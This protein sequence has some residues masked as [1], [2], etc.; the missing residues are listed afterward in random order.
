VRTLLAGATCALA[1]LSFAPPVSA[2]T[3]DF[4]P[5]GATP[6]FECA[7]FDV[8]L[9][10]S[11]QRG[12]TLKLSARRLVETREAPQA[13]IALAGGPGQSSTRFIE[14]FAD[15]LAEGLENRQ[16]VV[17]DQRG[18]GDSGPLRCAA[19]DDAAPSTSAGDLKTAVGRC[20]QQL[21]PAR[22]YYTATEV[23]EDLEAL[24]AGL[25]V[26][27]VAIF[28]VSSGSYVAQRYA[29]RYPDH[30]D[31]L[32]L[33]SAVAQDQSGP[34]DVS[35]YR[36]V[37][38]ML[39]QLCRERACRG[40]SRDPVQDLRRLA[41]RLDSAPLRA[42]VYDRRGR[43][44]IRRLASEAELFDLLVSSDLSPALRDGLPAAIHSAATGDP[45]P[46]VRL[47]AVDDGAADP[48]E[49]DEENERAEEF[50][51][52]LFFAS[53]C[54]EKP[55]PWRSAETPIADRPAQRKAALD[56]LGR[57]AFAPF[58]RPA[59]ESTQVGTAFCERWPET[60]I[61]PVPPPGEIGA[62]ALILSGLMDVRT[63]PQEAL[64]TAALIPD[65]SLVRVPGGGHSLVSSRLGCV[66]TA[67]T[68]FFA[69][70]A[71]GN[72]C[73]GV[74]PRAVTPDLAPLAPTHPR[75]VARA[76]VRGGATRVVAAAV[77]TV[78]D[79]AR[80]VAARGLLDSPFAFG[81]LRGGAACARPGELDAAGRRSLILAF[82]RDAY[83]PG[84][85]F[86]GRA[87]VTG[88][89]IARLRLTS[90]APG[91]RARLQLRGRRV[92]GTVAGRRVRARVASS[93]LTVPRQT[94]ATSLAR[95]RE[96]CR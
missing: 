73:A 55:L 69:D 82:R 44:S 50:S 6:D 61:A 35:S 33:D 96:R 72:P 22:R 1:S 11:G 2:A 76:G 46:L 87:V 26:E 48:R 29:R 18:T 24:R 77:A 32:V 13:L 39:R 10:P 41:A 5:C 25:D 81:G 65:A 78:Q 28:G 57:R 94:V 14:D 7:E 84:L 71:V 8:P 30:V 19:L 21:G 93:Q 67:L 91:R 92:S 62:P 23:V 75:R 38:R 34:F 52:A 42:R 9:D 47:L 45:A 16:L 4:S 56:A 36:A 85:A 66:E 53:T 80:V 51:N 59:A 27:R 63:P 79:A 86:S 15:L 95:T 3:L 31:R 58:G 60:T 49:F 17:F 64:R 83:V 37:A 40:I 70:Q 74:P 68:R 88:G 12:G 89:R 43:R 54:Q 90:S 20:G